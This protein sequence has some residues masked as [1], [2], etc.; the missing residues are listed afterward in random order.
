MAGFELTGFDRLVSL[1]TPIPVNR[2]RFTLAEVARATGGALLDVDPAREVV[3]VATDSRQ[4]PS[5][6]LFV[7]LAGETHDGHRFVDAARAAGALPL[8][9]AGRGLA[10][11]RVEVA[12]T[13]VALGSLAR[14]YVERESSGRAC[15][16]LAIGGAAGKTTTKTLAAAAVEALFGETLVTA[17]NLNNRIGVP[18]TLLTLDARHRAAVL[19]CATSWPGEVAELGR[20]V[21]PDVGVVLNV[22]V[23]HSERLGGLE[24]IADEEAGL[25]FAARRVAVTSADEPLLL[26]RLARAAAARL[27]FGS[28]EG[29][30]LRLLERAPRTD[31]GSDLLFQLGAGLSARGDGDRLIVT[32]RLLGAAFAANVAAALAGALALLGRPA[33]GDELAAAAAALATVTPVAGRMRP[34]ELGAWLVLDDSYNSNPR[35]AHAALAAGREIAERRGARLVVALGD[36]LE[37]GALGA[38]AHADLVAAARRSGAARLLLVG[39]LLARAA[40]AA[41]APLPESRFADSAAAAEELAPLLAPGDVILVKGSRGMRME[42][43]IERLEQVAAPR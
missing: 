30:D 26:E 6:S 41:T 13:L 38:E 12:D 25:F 28:A 42:R 34:L 7:A 16:R 32:T 11:P 33:S 27:T 43:L 1:A 35:S 8:V 5:G 20:I 21:A 22:D 2:A 37:L 9:A 40:A 24:S 29:A 31:G 4:L 18:M 14:A 36:M 15:P 39:P 17:G 19:E 10:G 23:E 3:G